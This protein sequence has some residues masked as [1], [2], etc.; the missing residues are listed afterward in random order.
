MSFLISKVPSN[1]NT[2]NSSICASASPC[3]LFEVSSRFKNNHVCIVATQLTS[4]NIS[5]EWPHHFINSSGWNRWQYPW[6][7]YIIKHIFSYSWLAVSSMWCHPIDSQQYIITTEY[8]PNNH[9]QTKMSPDYERKGDIQQGFKNDEVPNL[10]FH[11]TR[12]IYS[13]PVFVFWW[14]PSRHTKVPAA[15][16]HFTPWRVK[17]SSCTGKN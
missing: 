14:K 10:S 2:G 12:Y 4:G 8:T 17:S 11:V 7:L 13:Q 3:F 9:E 16:Q 15:F 6:E 1:A 5:S